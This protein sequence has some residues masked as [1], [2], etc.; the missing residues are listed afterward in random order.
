MAGFVKSVITAPFLEEND[1]YSNFRANAR[2]DIFTTT[3]IQCRGP[4]VYDTVY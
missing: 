2:L 1:L 3:K 4:L